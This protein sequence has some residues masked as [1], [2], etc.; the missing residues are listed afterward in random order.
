MKNVT[1]DYRNVTLFQ[2]DYSKFSE[3]AF[4][5]SFNKLSWNDINDVNL[6]INNKFDKFYEKVHLTVIEHVPLKKVNKKQLKLR[7]KPWVNSHIQKLIKHREK[8]LRKLRKSHSAA[9]EELYKKFRNRVVAENRKSKIQYYE[10]YFQKNTANM[11]NLWTGIKAIINTKS[12]SSLQN[13][14]QL[15]VDG[16]TH[17]DPQDIANMFN[18]FFVNVS[19]QVCSEIPRTKKSPLDYL[20][21]RNANSIFFKPIVSVEIQDII[22]GLDNSKSSGPYSVPVK[23]L[24]VLNPQIS[25]LLAQIFNES[26]SV[27]IFPDKLKYAKVIPIHKKGS[28]TD[29]SNYRPI[30]LLSVFSKIFEKLIHRRLYDFLDKLNIFYPLQFGFREKHSTNHALIS[31]T[32]AIRNT[33]DNQKYGCGVFIDLKKAFDTVNHS[34]LLRKLEHYGIRGVALDWF[35]SYLLGRKQ[36]VSVNGHISGYCEITCGVPQGSVLGP[37]LFLIYI[38]DLPSVSKSVAFYL[39][40]DDTNIYFEASDLFTLQKV[41][42]RELR[43]VKKWLD[44][45]KLSLNIDKTNFVVFHSPARKLAEPIVLKFGR[46]KISR[47]DHVRFLGVLLDETLG[48]KPHLVELS[49]K[50]SRSVGIFYK[51]RHYVPAD[52]LKTVYYALFY[53][54]LTYGITVWGATYDKFLNPVRIAQK[55]VVRAMTFSEPTAHSSP[56]FHD[57]K[58]LNFDD[59]HELLIAVFVYECHNNFAPSHF[60]DYFTQTSH[61]HSHNT[62]SAARGDFFMV[63]KNTLQYG[64]RSISFNGAKIWNN[65]PP[66]IR[67]SPSVRTFKNKLK[68]FLLDSYIS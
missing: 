35:T 48:W 39:F 12:K 41:L 57:L 28:P 60:A 15:V 47:T 1:I 22:T 54:F 20:K 59:L 50:L 53:P 30:S 19:S 10:N 33:I 23:L 65:I 32:E 37:L 18:K 52:T 56:L 6:N 26:L 51:L 8:L 43:H 38:N 63:R 55:K 27:G 21:R 61:I 46:K 68:N 29:P 13:I 49:R 17:T 64:L 44:A 14:S 40:A 5:N 31:M 16:K 4:V 66:E 62:R 11:K 42:N 7:L 9:I 36:Y 2:H 3:Q 25:E 67:D 24:K 45:N 34:I 58:L